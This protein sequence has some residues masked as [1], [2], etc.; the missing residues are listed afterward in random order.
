MSQHWTRKKGTGWNHDA[1]LGL[2][3]KLALFQG[4]QSPHTGSR[5]PRMSSTYSQRGAFRGRTQCQGFLHWCLRAVPHPEVVA[6]GAR[7]V[8]EGGGLPSVTSSIHASWRADSQSVKLL[9]DMCIYCWLFKTT[10][11]TEKCELWAI[12][13][14][15][16][17]GALY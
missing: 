2:L 6:V 5:K 15:W 14:T 9:R 7:A 4:I 12:N 17:E 11:N 8:W 13:R 1:L 3:I 10:D 16:Q